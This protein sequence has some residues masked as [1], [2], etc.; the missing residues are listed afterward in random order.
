MIKQQDEAN[1]DIACMAW[2]STDGKNDIPA[3]PVKPICSA[4]GRRRS[5]GRYQL[6]TIAMAM[7]P[8]AITANVGQSLQWQEVQGRSKTI[9]SVYLAISSEFLGFDNSHTTPAW[10]RGNFQ[11]LQTGIVYNIF[12]VGCSILEHNVR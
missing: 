8:R 12:Q 10:L 11:L 4:A 7:M 9:R 3:G 5:A 6:F 1:G 2:C